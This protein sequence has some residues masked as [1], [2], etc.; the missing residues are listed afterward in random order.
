MPVTLQE[1]AQIAIKIDEFR[2]VLRPRVGESPAFAGLVTELITM[3]DRTLLDPLG[4][5][6]TLLDSTWYGHILKGHPEVKHLRHFVEAALANPLEIRASRSDAD[7][8]LYYGP[9][10]RAGLL[11]QVVADVVAGVVKTAHFAKKISGGNLEWSP[12]SP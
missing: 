7:C 3:A 8:R 11:V 4:R 2:N 10:P 6:I 5:A 1:P 9:G 12:P